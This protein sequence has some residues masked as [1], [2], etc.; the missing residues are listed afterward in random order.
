MMQ[1]K[2]SHTSALLAVR[3]E[4]YNQ[5]EIKIDLG[6]SEH[7]ATQVSSEIGQSPFR[8]NL[9]VLFPFLCM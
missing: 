7:W 1:A 8:H 6:I 5:S 3:S 9:Q 4:G 2:E